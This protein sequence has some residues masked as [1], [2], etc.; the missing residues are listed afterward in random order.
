MFGVAYGTD[1]ECVKAI[2]LEEAARH[3]LVL[4]EPAPFARLTKQSEISLDFTLR[5][6]VES[7]NY[8][9]VNFDLLERINNRFEAEGIKIPF[10][11]LDVH[12]TK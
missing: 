6:W 12:I 11:Q 7:A 4:Q 1:V 8:W 10:N 2:L 5:V 3:E 9:Q